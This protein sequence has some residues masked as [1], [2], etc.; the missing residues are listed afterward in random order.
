MKTKSPRFIVAAS[1]IGLLAGQVFAAPQ[2]S[3]SVIPPLPADNPRS[4]GNAINNAGVATGLSNITG[5]SEAFTFFN[6]TT[7][8]LGNLG[9]GGGFTTGNGINAA[10]AVAGSGSIQPTPGT[11]FD[12]A[13]IN[14]PTQN[15]RAFTVIHPLSGGDRSNASA[16][17]DASVVIGSSTYGGS[18]SNRQG[19]VARPSADASQ[20]YVAQPLGFL[21]NGNRSF[22]NA[23]NTNGL[24]GGSSRVASSGSTFAALFDGNGGVMALSNPVGTTTSNIFGINDAAVTVGTFSTGGNNQAVR[25]AADGAPTPLGFLSGGTF[26]QANDVNNLGDI[27]GTSS[28]TAGNNRAFLFTGGQM[29]DLNEFLTGTSDFSA[30]TF[31]QGINDLGQITG[32]GTLAAGGIRGFVLTPVVPEP[33]SLGL[34]GLG[35]AGLLRRQRRIVTPLTTPTR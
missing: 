2:Y 5:N 29:L 21:P 25:W 31:A 16:L 33:A 28:A 35:A 32:Y 13:Y 14:Q 22:A 26:S 9:L 3:L 30:L 23:I 17:N 10:G 24:I 18:T 15:G 20:H 6:G 19:F 1:V 4:Q 27:V 11:F 34:L 12:R 8:S 7:T